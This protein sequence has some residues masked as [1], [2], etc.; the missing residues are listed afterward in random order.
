MVGGFLLAFRSEEDARTR[1]RPPL[2]H[3]SSEAPEG[4]HDVSNMKPTWFG[5]IAPV[6]TASTL[7]FWGPPVRPDS[8]AIIGLVHQPKAPT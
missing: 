3:R 1:F 7:R 5:D 2:P 6:S 8:A 4:R